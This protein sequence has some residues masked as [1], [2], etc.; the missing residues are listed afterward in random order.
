MCTV[1]EGVDSPFQGEMKIVFS[2]PKLSKQKLGVLK[3]NCF[4]FLFLFLFFF[5]CR[6]MFVTSKQLAYCR[7]VFFMKFHWFHGNYEGIQESQIPYKD[8]SASHPWGGRIQITKTTHSAM[9]HM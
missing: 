5:D 9:K 4:L 2:W 8:E 7:P 6:H 3:L 1:L